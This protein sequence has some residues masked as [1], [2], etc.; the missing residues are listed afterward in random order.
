MQ[1]EEASEASESRMIEDAFQMASDGLMLE[2]SGTEVLEMES[3]LASPSI[4]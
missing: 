2:M 1:K 3:G 4:L